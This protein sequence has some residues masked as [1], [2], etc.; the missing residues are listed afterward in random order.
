MKSLKSWF[1]KT[2]PEINNLKGDEKLIESQ[3]E[4]L[5][6]N[7]FCCGKGIVTSLTIKGQSSIYWRLGFWR[8]GGRKQNLKLR[9][10]SLAFN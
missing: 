10:M 9:Q 1:P 4:Y 7:G 3:K 8:A 6:G 5:Y 2:I